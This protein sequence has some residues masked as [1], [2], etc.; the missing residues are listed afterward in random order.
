MTVFR[1]TAYQWSKELKASG[2]P[3]RWNLRGDS[4]I[5]TAESWSLACL[6]NLV[7]RSGEGNNNL[8]KVMVIE[9]P[10]TVRIS[11]IEV[12]SLKKD[13]YTMENYN[14]CQDIGSKWLSEYKTA[15]L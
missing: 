9:I 2:Y 10:E 7:H 5:Y 14:Y 12:S 1:I 3:A 6:E 13:W 15:V 4:V 11:A 8:F